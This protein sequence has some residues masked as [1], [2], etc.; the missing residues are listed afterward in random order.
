MESSKDHADGTV[1]YTKTEL[2]TPVT[3]G[4]QRGLRQTFS[5]GWAP[6]DL[7]EDASQQSTLQADAEEEE[8]FLE[9][10]TKQQGP[11]M[12]QEP[13]QLLLKYRAVGAAG[14]AG[15]CV[16]KETTSCS[17][18]AVYLAMRLALIAGCPLLPEDVAP[19]GWQHLDCACGGACQS[20]HMT[21]LG[22]FAGGM[23]VET[24]RRGASLHIDISSA[25]DCAADGLSHPQRPGAAVAQDSMSLRLALK[26]LQVSLW[27][28]ERRIILGLPARG[29]PGSMPH[30]Q[31]AF[32]L[33][34][35]GLVVSA[36][37]TPLQGQP[38]LRMAF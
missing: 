14:W 38:L 2:I 34:L 20:L 23:R 28:D 10:V 26:C 8:A 25:P 15:Q 37:H 6:K 31:E 21:Q 3:A 30:E 18:G 17:T 4:S 27:D 11:V 7:R 33:T 36:T 9:A 1:T 22:A 19:A 12:G 13:P 5:Q 35:D 24:T 32:C 16:L 29:T